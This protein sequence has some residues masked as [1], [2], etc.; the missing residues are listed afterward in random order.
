[1]K[2]DRV[3]GGHTGSYAEIISL[4]ATTTLR[5]I[6]PS[7]HFAGAAGIC[8]TLP[9]SYA[10]L[11]SRAG[12]KTGQTVLVHAAAG[13]LGI[14]AVQVAKAYGCRVICTAGSDEK[15]SIATKY[16]AD[17]CINYSTRPDWWKEVLSVTDDK[18]VDV[19]YDPV[20]LVD[21]SLKCIA[22]FGKLLVVGFAGGAIEKVAMNRVLLKQ[23]SL[24]GYV[25]AIIASQPRILPGLTLEAFRREPPERS[26]RGGPALGRPAAPHR[27]REDRP[28]GLRP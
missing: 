8:A 12:I 17:H 3:F 20:G 11:V 28:R 25:S 9:V 13:G 24:I 10:A 23:V 27:R 26:C 21:L 19:V 16:G 15:C 2:G 6:P 1:M 7:W 14:M 18:G 4:P 5:R 22:H